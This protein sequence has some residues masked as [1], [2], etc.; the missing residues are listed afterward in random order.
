MVIIEYENGVRS[1]FHTNCNSA[2]HERRMYI[3]GSLGTLRANLIG[4]S[5]EVKKIGD[6]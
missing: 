3:N 4:N 2:L 1:T 6:K 5:L